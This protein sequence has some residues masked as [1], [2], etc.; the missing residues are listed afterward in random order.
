MQPNDRTL[1]KPRL[2]VVRDFREEGWPSMDLVADMMLE[3]LA[4]ASTSITAEEIAPRFRRVIGAIPGLSRNR[5]VR[6]F[7]RFWNRFVTLPRV[8]RA[9]IPRFDAFH[10]VDHSYAHLVHSLP[11]NRTGVYCHDLDAFRCLLEPEKEPRPAWF[12]MMT[13]RILTGLQ[14][15]AIVFLI[16]R[17][18]GEELVRR[19]L[20]Q[21]KRLRLVPLGVAK[22]F[23]PANG[24]LGAPATE[25]YATRSSPY[26]LHIGSCIPRKRIDLLLDLFARLRRDRPELMLVKAG[27]AWTEAQTAQIERLGIG[28]SIR[29]LGRP[30]RSQLADAIRRATVVV[31]P[32][33]AEGFGLPV[34]ESLA[35]GTAVVASDIA[36]LR[37]AGGTVASYA[38][39]GD[40]EA[41]V[42]TIEYALQSSGDAAATRRRIEWASQ[43]SW[44]RQARDIASAYR[45]LIARG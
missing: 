36:T 45:E 25:E 24:S 7:D 37:E 17:A 6:N 41:W 31:I 26:L 8:V 40:I 39:V 15:A 3:H 21:P 12:R 43:F 13:Q 5:S 44:E 4:A 14:Q 11:A 29:H 1:S 23:S 33:D 27:D 32:S 20:V 19:K 38:P 22:E 30:S 42:A 28:G 35:C 18:V 16:S 2:A 10:I 34:I 9:A